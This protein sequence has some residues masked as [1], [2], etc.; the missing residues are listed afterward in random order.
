[1]AKGESTINQNEYPEQLYGKRYV[2]S[3]TTESIF[4][5][6]IKIYAGFNPH[7]HRHHHSAT[8]ALLP[9]ALVV[10]KDHLALAIEDHARWPKVAMPSA[11]TP[12]TAQFQPST[13]QAISDIVALVRCFCCCC[14]S[15]HH[16][17]ISSLFAN[18]KE[19]D[20][21][22]TT[23]FKILFEKE[24]GRRTEQKDEQNYTVLE[25]QTQFEDERKTIVSTLSQLWHGLFKLPLTIG[26]Y[27][28]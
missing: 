24:G 20:A 26:Y 9:R 6:F 3:T 12:S 19:L 25:L 11:R 1:M 10:T 27:N 4:H 28:K 14:C 8:D 23:N 16:L 21:Q 18:V 2:S 22:D 17:L 15:S 5:L 7:H 13:L